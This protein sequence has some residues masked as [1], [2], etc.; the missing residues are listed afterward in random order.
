MAF[1]PSY[2]RPSGFGEKPMDKEIR[3]HVRKQ[4]LSDRELTKLR[5][6]KQFNL[7]TFKKL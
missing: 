6:L 7:V 2:G 4:Y 5:K 1:G 3:N